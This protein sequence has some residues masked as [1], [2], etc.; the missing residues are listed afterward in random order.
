M[1]HLQ[2]RLGVS[3]SVSYE[4]VRRLCEAGLLER[5]RVLWG[6]PSLIR[7]TREG[8]AFSGLGLLVARVTAGSQRHWSACAKVALWIERQWGR[9]AHI[10]AREVMLAEFLAGRPLYSAVVGRTQ[11]DSPALHR[12]DLVIVAGERPVAVE[13]ELTPKSPGRLQGI[14]RG[15]RRSRLVEKA[16]YLCPEGHAYEAVERALRKIHGTDTVEL[17]R[18]EAVVGDSRQRAA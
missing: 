10:S 6:E 3:R 15:W 18:L 16:I 8:I 2:E 1:R 5:L 9:E 11:V 13:V 14:L 7:A 4:V 12:P 17:V